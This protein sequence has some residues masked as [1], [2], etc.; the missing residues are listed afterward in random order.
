[1]FCNRFI[2][3][4]AHQQSSPSSFATPHQEHPDDGG[5]QQQRDQQAEGQVLHHH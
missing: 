4:G 3:R 2:Q 1:L 5:V